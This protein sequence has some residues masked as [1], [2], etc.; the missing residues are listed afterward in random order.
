M[1]SLPPL[2]P[3]CMVLWQDAFDRFQYALVVQFENHEH[4]KEVTVIHDQR[5]KSLI[6]WDKELNT[7][8]RVLHASR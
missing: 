3:G 8:W 1:A 5:V 7:R 6:L 2:L 4:H